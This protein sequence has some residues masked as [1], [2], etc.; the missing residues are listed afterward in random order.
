VI[1]SPVGLQWAVQPAWRRLFGYLNHQSRDGSLSENLPLSS[2]QSNNLDWPGE[3][4]SQFAELLRGSHRD[5]FVFIYSLVQNRADAEDVYQQ[6]TLVLW[7]KF[8]EFTPGTNFA[9]WATRVAHLTAQHFIRSRRRQH[10]YFSDEMLDSLLEVQR[11][12]GPEHYS[13]RMEALAKCMEKLPRRDRKLV[14]RCYGGDDVPAIAEAENRT[15]ASIYQAIYR[16]RKNL[17]SCVERT[18][19]AEN[20]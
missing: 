20:R 2:G 10:L 8:S 4:A 7:S 5:I 15:V 18:L 11:P 19:A 1:A 17:F 6:T 12:Q 16:I 3:Q 14:D 13:M 9:A